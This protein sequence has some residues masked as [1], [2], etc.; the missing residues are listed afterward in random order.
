MIVPIAT[1]VM[2]A[3]RIPSLITLFVSTAL[4]TVFAVIFQP[5]LL[6]EIAGDAGSYVMTLTKGAL[7]TLFTNT[8]L[9]TGNVQINDLIA[10]RGISGMMDTV[11]LIL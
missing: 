6:V 9:E 4:A 11:W 2:I 8:S 7:A 3:K 5:N 10:T 1:G